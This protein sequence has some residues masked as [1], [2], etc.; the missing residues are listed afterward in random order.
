MTSRYPVW[1]NGSPVSIK[2]NVL[3]IGNM[4]LIRIDHV[5]ILHLIFPCLHSHTAIPSLALPALLC[6]L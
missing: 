1:E 5:V 4:G 6:N 2:E 3:R